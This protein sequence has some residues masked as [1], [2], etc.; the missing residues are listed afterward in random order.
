[1][2]LAVLAV[3]SRGDVQPYVALAEGL[4]RAGHAVRVGTHA[5][6]ADLVRARG[7]E[8]AELGANPRELLETEAAAAWIASR[9]PVA[10][11]RNLGDLAR[12]LA[13]AL[14][15]DILRACDGAD[16]IVTSSLAGAGIHVAEARGVPHVAAALQPLSPTAA[17]PS[18]LVPGLD[19]LGPRG[20]RATHRAA[21]IAF[22][23]PFRGAVNAWR[24]DALG[25]A[26]LR[27]L[28]F[29]GRL[30]REHR[31]VLYGFSP[32]VV[33]KPADWGEWL[34]VCGYWSLQAGA[35]WR[36]PPALAAFLAAGPPP[37]YVGFGSMRVADPERTSAVLADG[38]ARAG[39]RG[40]IGA[41]WAG[42]ASAPGHRS[43]DLFT[44]GDVPHDWL[45][46]RCA[47]V[48]THGGA[49]T[50]ATALRAGVP[51]FAVPFFADQFFWGARTARLGVGP[52]PVPLRRLEAGRFAAGVRAAVGTPAMRAR[53]A[54][55]GRALARE[56]GVGVAVVQVERAMGGREVPR[57][58]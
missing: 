58:E 4:A 52:A 7:L 28:D 23:L 42:L 26:P 56:D 40:L 53:A 9:N 25:L 54:V 50:T 35:G 48:V 1:M 5:P 57:R 46:P 39:V 55:V 41:G 24:R 12:P 18:V 31:P 45:F 13:L 8:F 43:G 19:W 47:A 34:H 51:S 36:P 10:F 16:G 20:R 22:D 3:G 15:D 6:F 2:R 30:D 37:V 21:A 38:L 14:A 17:F 27:D 44:V 49:G 11:F 32:V 29:Y 33:P